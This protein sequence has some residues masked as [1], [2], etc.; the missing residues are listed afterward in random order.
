MRWA[1]GAVGTGI[2]CPGLFWHCLAGVPS[3]HRYVAV[4]VEGGKQLLPQ[5][6]LGKSEVWG[7]VGRLQV[8][9]EAEWGPKMEVGGG[10]GA[11]R[12]IRTRM[13]NT[14]RCKEHLGHAKR[15]AEGTAHLQ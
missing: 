6:L 9:L 13:G 7:N 8:S 4:P 12:G 2:P 1:Q 14:Q 10:R 15:Q 11:Q 3:H 5:P